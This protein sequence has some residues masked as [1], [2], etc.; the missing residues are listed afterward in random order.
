[1]QEETLISI[2]IPIYNSEKFIER[3]VNSLI[4]QSN[5]NFEVI[6][7]DDFSKDNSYSLIC[8]MKNN[9]NFKYKILRNNKNSGPGIT[10]NN[11]IQN[12]NGKYITFIDSDDFVSNNFIEEL[13][14]IIC[15]K[16]YDIVIFD[17]NMINK[18]IN[19][20]YGLPFENGEIKV[21]D[22]LALSNG[23]CWGKLYRRDLIVKNN[24]YFPNLIRSEDLAFCKVFISKCEHVYYLKKPIYNYT[25]N[26]NSI[27]RTNTTLDFKNNILAFEYIKNRVKN[28]EA[29][30]IIFIREYLYLVVQIMILKKCKTIQIKKFIDESVKE[31]KYWEKNK[32]LKFQPFYVRVLLKFIKYRLI[33]P[34]RIIFKLKE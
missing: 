25:I 33:F 24:I 30:E 14:N 16:E 17:Y 3:C 15:K 29:L 2:V 20:H 32:Y 12:C 31:Y 8:N 34:L 4:N 27:M 22:T 11:G 10:R 21:L 28:S 6:F 1:M 13:T 23:M 19:R 7:V 5:S 9:Y 26:K 18:K